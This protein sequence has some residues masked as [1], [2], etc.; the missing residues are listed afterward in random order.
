MPDP[1][2]NCSKESVEV[3]TSSTWVFL[4]A[5]VISGITTFMFYPLI[6]LE[7]IDRGVG[8]GAT[9]LILGLLSGT[10]QILSGL[11]GTVNARLGSKTLA[12]GG[13][14]L[15]S[16]GLLVFAFDSSILLYAVGAVV[17]SL[18][19]SLIHI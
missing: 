7:L 18:G 9:G 19:L 13:L 12:I 8:A 5:I 2:K 3:A 14:A 16:V 15:R 6:T 11:I 4:V 1:S 17:A 10:G